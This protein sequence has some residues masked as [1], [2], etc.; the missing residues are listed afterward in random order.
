MRFRAAPGL[1]A[2]TRF[3]FG[4]DHIDIPPGGIVLTAEQIKGFRFRSYGE[5]V[6]S[7]TQPDYL[8][9]V[10]K[11]GDKF[12]VTARKANWNVTVTGTVMV[13]AK[14]D[15]PTLP[16]SLQLDVSW[17]ALDFE[18]FSRREMILKSDEATDFAPSPALDK[19]LREDK[20]LR[21]PFKALLGEIIT[22]IGPDHE[23][24]SK[25]AHLLDRYM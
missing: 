24:E 13:I 25:L 5:N 1:P 6:P 15:E 12:R 14:F 22:Y 8:F 18:H 19:D 21:I 2:S 11:T 10:T 7:E 23:L 9:G 4:E 3:T 17:K 20:N 16:I